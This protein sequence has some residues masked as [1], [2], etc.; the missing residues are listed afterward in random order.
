MIKHKKTVASVTRGMAA[1]AWIYVSDPSLDGVYVRELVAMIPN[2]LHVSLSGTGE[3]SKSSLTSN[4][5]LL[6]SITLLS[7]HKGD[8]QHD[9]KIEKAV[10]IKATA[11][12]YGHNFVSIDIR[13]DLANSSSV[14]K[15]GTNHL[16]IVAGSNVAEKIYK[17]LCKHDNIRYVS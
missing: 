8:T 16:E 6:T 10:A 12:K 1:A 3:V 13:N 2:V 14:D 4:K 5:P 17:W 11:I 7:D 15:F 9:L